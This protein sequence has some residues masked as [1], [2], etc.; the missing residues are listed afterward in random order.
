MMDMQQNNINS[1]NNIQTE[2]DIIN[3]FDLPLFFLIATLSFFDGE[4]NRSGT[5]LHSCYVHV[6][7]Q[8]MRDCHHCGSQNINN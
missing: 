2:Q 8:K 6:M 3:D 1:T 4:S 5:F 7:C